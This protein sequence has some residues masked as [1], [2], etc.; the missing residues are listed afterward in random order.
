MSDHPLGLWI[1][2][3]CSVD[4]V[5]GIAAIRCQATTTQLRLLPLGCCC[6]QSLRWQHFS[7]HAGA[8]C[9]PHGGPETRVS[10]VDS[11][12]RILLFQ[13]ANLACGEVICA[14]RQ[15][16]RTRNR[17]WHHSPE[18]QRNANRV[19]FHCNSGQPRGSHSPRTPFRDSQPYSS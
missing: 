3:N 1:W 14:K 9:A 2:V 15:L 4:E 6:L 13:P 19:L 11:R 8:P 16:T 7:R 12:V 17:C 10:G 5:H 18:P